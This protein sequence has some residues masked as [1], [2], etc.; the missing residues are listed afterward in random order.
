[1]KKLLNQLKMTISDI[2]L[3]ELNEA[4]A[5]QCVAVIRDLH[6]PMD[7]VNISGGA[8]ALGHPL[9]DSGARIVTTLINNL[10]QT[11]Q[12]IGIASLCMGGGM[13]SALAIKLI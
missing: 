5:A 4:F 2:D 11:K 8:I 6:L 3:V 9:G 7:K 10:K 12:E 1:M 13:G